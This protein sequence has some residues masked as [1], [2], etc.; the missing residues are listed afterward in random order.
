M[1][2]NTFYTA[3]RGKNA[4]AAFAEAVRRAQYDHGHGGYSG[5]IVEKQEFTLIPLPP[6]PPT[7]MDAARELISAEDPRVNDKWGPAGC[8]DL[9]GGSFLFFGWASS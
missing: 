8:F 1:G 7:P 4:S 6:P 5:T 9:G 3:A 2:A